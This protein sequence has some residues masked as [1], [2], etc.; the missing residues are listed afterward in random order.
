MISRR[1]FLKISIL[2]TGAVFS[3]TPLGCGKQNS[4][5]KPVSLLQNADEL[6][7]RQQY[8]DLAHKYI[9]EKTT[10]SIVPEKRVQC[11]VAV[12]GSGPSGLSCAMYLQKLGYNVKVVENEERAGGVAI[13]GE[14]NSLKFP[15]ASIYFVDYTEYIKEVCAFAG[16]TPINPTEDSYRLS[17]TSYKSMWS[18]NS[19]AQMDLSQYDK[20]AFK[21]FRDSMIGIN[22]TLPLYPLQEIL[23]AHL[24]KL[25]S[26]SVETFLSQF[27]SPTL[28]SIIEL[29]TRSSMGG[30]LNQVNTF[31]FQ[32]FYASEIGD[33]NTSTKYTFPGGMNGLTNPLSKALGDETFLLGH[34][35]IDVK[36][37]KSGA[38]VLTVNRDEQLIAIDCKHVVMANQ[39]YQAPMLVSEMPAAQ[40]NAI[41]NIKYAPF[42]TVHLCSDEPIITQ[43]T[44]DIWLQKSNNLYTDII[45]ANEL[46]TK[47]KSAFVASVYSPRLPE[48]RAMLQSNDILVSLSRKIAED[49]CKEFKVDASVVKEIQSFAWG[50][51]LV[52]PTVGSHNGIAQAARRSI[53]NIHF[54]NTDNDCAPAVENAVYNGYIAAEKISNLLKR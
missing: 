24:A 33:G 22:D 38:Q 6:Q 10:H 31:C 4:S 42:V 14:Y 43:N 51:S 9:R 41:K 27:K 16:V 26:M 20:T 3:T 19:I 8:F 52:Q 32:N 53:S 28:N 44:F 50:H 17:G 30:T 13:S 48:D 45:N 5:S 39:K 46:D 12:I 7:I 37:T 1:D 11:D 35:C 40:V 36:N 34:L 18:D 49:V 2:S 25:D 15:F 54:A 47:N 23:P 21:L 29:Y